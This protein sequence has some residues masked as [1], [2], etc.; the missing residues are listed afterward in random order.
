M[1]GARRWALSD[2]GTGGGGRPRRAGDPFAS[3]AS[4]Q[5]SL[6]ARIRLYDAVRR[7]AQRGEVDV[8]DAPDS[9]GWCAG[10]PKLPVPVVM[11]V[12]GSNTYFAHEAGRP[13]ARMT[14][15]LERSSARRADFWCA[16]SRYAAERTQAIFGL[17]PV[18]AVVYPAIVVPEESDVDPEHR[19]PGKVIFT[20]N[21]TPKKGVVSLIDAWAEVK[22]A[23]ADAQLHFVGPTSARVEGRPIVEYLLNRLPDSIR[24]SVSFHGPQPH[25]KLRE[26]LDRA[27]VAVY[28]S[29]SEAF[30]AA[31]MEAMAHG[32]ATIYSPRA[33]GRE[34]IEHGRNGLLVDPDEPAEIARSIVRLLEDQREA[35]RLARAGRESVAERFSTEAAVRPVHAFFSECVE[36]YA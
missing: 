21:V 35:A 15:W 12:H 18:G 26:A 28:P 14:A 4:G 20:G 29:Y 19:D 22:R 2:R 33:S 31:P 7:M 24:L 5:G 23:R 30:A 3:A 8:V 34:L 25:S 10:W 1:R 13:A 36:T 16:V 17:S 6:R 11:H 32:C 9:Q 27:R